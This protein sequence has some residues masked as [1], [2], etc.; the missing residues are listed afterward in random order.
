MATREMTASIP[1]KLVAKVDELA[2]RMSLTYD[3]IVAQALA[4]WVSDE[5]ERYQ[6]TLEGLAD[7]DA[8][9]VFDHEV[10]AAWIDSL[11]TDHPLPTP[12]LPE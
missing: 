10:I 2:A 5:E 3:E 8:G 4:K 12:T 6:M 11:G 7:V 1:A 9:R